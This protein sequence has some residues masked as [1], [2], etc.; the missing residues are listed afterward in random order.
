MWVGVVVRD[1]EGEV[2]LA[3][4]KFAAGISTPV[5]EKLKSLWS[6]LQLCVE[7]N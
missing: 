6:A 5:V 4:Y 1:D 3:L 7:L 2:L